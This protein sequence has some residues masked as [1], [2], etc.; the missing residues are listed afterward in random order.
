MNTTT[1][2]VENLPDDTEALR[3]LVI[4][5]LA[6]RDAL[7]SERDSLAEQNDRIRHL[8]LKLKRMQ[9]GAKSERL[10]EDQ[11]QLGLEDLEQ[12]IARNDAEAEKRDP[13][14]KKAN[15]TS[16]GPTGAYY[17]PTCRAST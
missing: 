11:L 17:R 13:E 3:A 12:A 15:T 7:I 9:F 4:A 5:L 2:T 10:P 6:E 8:L 16:A 14:Q 1:D